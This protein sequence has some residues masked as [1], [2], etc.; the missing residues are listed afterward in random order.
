MGGVITTTSSWRW[1]YLFNAPFSVVG[2]IT[3]L[4]S[5]PRQISTRKSPKVSLQ[6]LR[7]VD[8][9]GAL[10]LLAASALLVFAIQEAGGDSYAWN[11]GTIIGTLVVSSVCWLAFFVWTYWLSLGKRTHRVRA[12]FPLTIAMTRPTGPAIIAIFSSGFSYLI[13]IINLPQ[14]LQIANGNT[15]ILAGVHLLPLLCSMALGSGLG[16]AV[17][18]KRNFTSHT[19]IVAACLILLGCGLMSTIKETRSID[20][21]VYGYQ[22]ILGLGTGLTFSSV[23]IMTNMSNSRS[24]AAAAQGAISQ[25]RILGGS[26]GLAIATIVLNNK[27]DKKLT[28][29]LNPTQLSNLKQS[30]STIR[31]LPLGEQGAVAQVYSNSFNQQMR[32][33]TYLSVVCVVASLATYSRTPASIAA[34]RAKQEAFKTESDNNDINELQIS[35]N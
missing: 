2:I 28:G 21:A 20:T 19:L 34:A 27:L 12:I 17:S 7:S 3:L 18:S 13:A 14:R 30:L 31:E 26:I 35:D 16:G 32:I 24:N 9:L 33:C 6:S 11:S 8:F 5:W 10:L 25:A 29:V 4:V 15:P 1:I 23:T 22:F